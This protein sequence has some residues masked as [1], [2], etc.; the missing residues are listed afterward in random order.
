MKVFKKIIL[1]FLLSSFLILLFSGFSFAQRKL[2]TIYPTVPGVETPTT[3]KTAL[4]E[5]LKYVFTFAIMVA[6]LLAFGA[7]IYGGFSYLT[8][9]GDPSKMKDGQD[10]I[11]AG[12]LG[13]IIVLS[14]FLILNTI[15]PQLVLPGGVIQPGKAGIKIYANSNDC[16]ETPTAGKEP[17]D[18]NE[19]L[20][21]QS[22]PALYVIKDSTVILD[23]G[24]EGSYKISSI[25]FLSNPGDLTI[26]FYSGNDY[27]PLI[28]KY[29][30]SNY[31]EGDCQPYVE[32]Q[33]KSVKLDYHLPGVYLYATDN[34][35]GNKYGEDYVTYQASSATLQDFDNKTKSIKFVYG[36]KDSES[37]EYRVRYAAILHEKENFMGEAALF[38]Q[39]QNSCLNL[40]DVAEL[41]SNIPDNPGKYFGS[42][43][44]GISIC[45]AATSAALHV[46]LDEEGPELW[47]FH[48]CGL[49]HEHFDASESGYSGCPIFL[50][51]E[52]GL[53][54]DDRLIMWVHKGETIH[55]GG[56]NLID[57]ISYDIC[58]DQTSPGC[59]VAWG[60]RGNIGGAWQVAQESFGTGFNSNGDK[61]DDCTLSVSHTEYRPR[62][63][64]YCNDDG[65]WEETPPSPPPTCSDTDGGKVYDEKGI[66]EVSSQ[67]T[68]TCKDTNTLYEWYCNA[69]NDQ[70]L[71][72]EHPCASGEKCIDGECTTEHKCDDTD[73]GEIWDELGSCYEDDV[74]QGTDHCKAGSATEL[75]E[76]Y[77]DGVKCETVSHDCS[78]NGCKDGVCTNETP[79]CDDSDEG[80]NFTVNGT[81]KDS[82]GEYTDS[83]INDT[84]LKEWY[85]EGDHCTNTTQKCSPST[86]QNGK[87]VGVPNCMRQACEVLE[88]ASC[89]CGTLEIQNQYCC[90]KLNQGYG[91][92]NTCL[93]A[94]AGAPPSP[95]KGY[96]AD[97]SGRVSSIT[98]YVKPVGEIIG[99]GVRFCE[100][101]NCPPDGCFL[102]ETGSPPYPADT[103]VVDLETSQYEKCGYDTDNKICNKDKSC[104]NRISAMEMDG[105]YI[106]LLCRN[107]DLNGD[108]EVF[109]SSCADFR[110]HRIGQCGPWGRKDCLSSF[111][112]KAR[113]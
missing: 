72:E 99:Q 8:S 2:E 58:P 20:V 43:P 85:C 82:S 79:S 33:P 81:C 16:G 88:E 86:C 9:A 37:G 48:S 27:A 111:I 87:C 109:T 19:F 70:C 94:C 59:K 17:Q 35:T 55:K 89:M 3:V 11:I 98:V 39:E 75:V 24:G 53:G 52:N 18:I 84:F 26:E 76:W 30:E 22:Y 62:N 54:G 83:C 47:E 101:K 41:S 15:N 61:C 44:T 38:D 1:I 25:K 102:P 63:D 104:D 93:A 107:P 60:Y 66:C 46:K 23:W 28:K 14:S 6:G 97:L 32:S 91:D 80:I 57:G 74:F 105:N 78:P 34:C 73:N 64:L 68:D 13:L 77:C 69:T 31:K 36:D 110:N 29:D 10:Q 71:M 112:I 100:D 65:L 113:K 45:E 49:V 92:R 90:A 103:I 50:Q 67:F 106:A 51:N 21:S 56:L 7:L 42:I 4:P 12:I 5:Y 40:S 95:G 96:G 108:C